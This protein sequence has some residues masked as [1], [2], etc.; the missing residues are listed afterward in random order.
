MKRK[1]CVATDENLGAEDGLGGGGRK[2]MT[3]TVLP[4]YKEEKG[5]LN[6]DGRKR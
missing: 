3:A 5:R 1:P 2:K 6:G 4:L